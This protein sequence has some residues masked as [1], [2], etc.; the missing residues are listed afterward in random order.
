MFGE[1][2]W[3]FTEEMFEM[4]ITHID[5]VATTKS[6]KKGPSRPQLT[7]GPSGCS[8][9]KLPTLAL[10]DKKSPMKSEDMKKA[11]EAI[12]DADRG[13][14]TVSVSD[15]SPEKT[16]GK[17]TKAIARDPADASDMPK[18]KKECVRKK[19]NLEAPDA[20]G[21]NL[22]DDVEDDA[23]DGGDDEGGAFLHKLDGVFNG[24]TIPGSLPKAVRI[25]AKKLQQASLFGNVRVSKCV[26][27][28]VCVC[29]G[30]VSVCVYVL[31]CLRVC[32]CVCVY[33]CVCVC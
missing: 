19:E 24:G 5:S 1:P 11:P 17:K 13:D 26:C 16:K 32:V 2:T 21:E 33:V 9:Q 23:E 12:A 30:V 6:S 29:V 25:H 20:K 10:M 15:D 3:V 4:C 14:D 8:K 31:V 27:A 22:T 18:T 7:A 28:C